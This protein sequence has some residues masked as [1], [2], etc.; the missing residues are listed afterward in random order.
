MKKYTVIKPDYVNIHKNILP[1]NENIKII[2]ELVKSPWYLAQDNKENIFKE[3]FNFNRGFQICTF[4]TNKD[5]YINE[6]NLLNDFAKKIFNI[7]LNLQNEKGELVRINWNMYLNFS[8]P[9]YHTD[10]DDIGYKSILYSLHTTDGGILIKNYLCGDKMGE[11]KIFNSNILHKGIRPKRD[12]V[13]FNLNI[14]YK[15]IS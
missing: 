1:L 7:I 8:K 5:N 9:S 13:R 12:R 4:N 3:I 15:V 6:N 14:I 2:G 11:A 10:I